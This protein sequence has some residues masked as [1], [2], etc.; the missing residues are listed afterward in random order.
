MEE[1][2]VAPEQEPEPEQTGEEPA[3]N[4]ASPKPPV[5][6]NY[7]RAQLAKL[8][9]KKPPQEA[10]GENISPPPKLTPD[11]WRAFARR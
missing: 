8:G 2:E 9:A 1:K 7:H 4:T 5:E 6:E 11:D 10:G 3:D